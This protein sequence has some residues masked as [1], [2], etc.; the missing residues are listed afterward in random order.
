MVWLFTANG[1]AEGESGPCRWWCGGRCR[2]RKNGAPACGQ[3]C[4]NAPNLAQAGI[5]LY[6]QGSQDA[7][8]LRSRSQPV[9]SPCEKTV[10]VLTEY[11]ARLRQGNFRQTPQIP[12]RSPPLRRPT[13][14]SGNFQKPCLVQGVDYIS[15]PLVLFFCLKAV[16]EAKSKEIRVSED[17]IAWRTRP[18]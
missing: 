1:Q 11:A 7:P 16:G 3:Y 17:A 14:G 5:Y 13:N 2:S 18:A 9:A 10:H 8:G 12:V 15:M 4:L 6:F